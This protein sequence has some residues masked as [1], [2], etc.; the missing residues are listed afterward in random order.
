MV[1]EPCLALALPVLRLLLVLS[2]V[3]AAVCFMGM[4]ASLTMYNYGH[5]DRGHC[6]CLL[7]M[8]LTYTLA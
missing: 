5:N 7:T 4:L 3:V 6:S 1:W 8:T 2:G